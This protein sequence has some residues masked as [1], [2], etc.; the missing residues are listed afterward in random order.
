L[1]GL[2]SDCQNGEFKIASGLSESCSVY[3]RI[4]GKT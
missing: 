4:N 2:A 1:V 3:D